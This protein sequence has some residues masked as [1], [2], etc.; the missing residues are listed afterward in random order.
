MSTWTPKDI[1]N[2]YA[3]MQDPSRRWDLL[4]VSAASSV[5]RC[6][7]PAHQGKLGHP[8]SHLL[9]S[10]CL[11][12]ITIFNPWDVA[13]HAS[14]ETGLYFWEKYP[15]GNVPGDNDRAIGLLQINLNFNAHV[16]GLE[17][18]AVNLP[19]GTLILAQFG[20]ELELRQQVDVTASYWPRLVRAAYN[21]GVAGALDGL[22][23]H[24]GNP[25][26]HTA[27]G[28]KKGNPPGDYGQD[29]LNRAAAFKL[30]FES[31]SGPQS[32]V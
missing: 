27:V 1:Q 17:K 13:G 5:V 20:D 16:T 25:D 26:W 29:V 7:T 14:R 15:A 19:N 24:G 8:L 11:S 21:A 28:G 18:P 12:P 32:P 3:F 9:N 22:L 4:C 2:E 10:D 23:N 30:L 6:G 31:D